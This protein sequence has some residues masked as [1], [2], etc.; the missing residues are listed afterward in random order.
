[1][2]RVLLCIVLLLAA[3]C[4]DDQGLRERVKALET[5]L[6]EA[7][8]RVDELERQTVVERDRYVD[9]WRGGPTASGPLLAL[10]RLGALRWTCDDDYGVR[11]VFTAA[12]ATVRVSYDAPDLSRSGLIHPGQRVGATVAAGESVAWT[13]AHRH[14]PGFIRAH[15]EVATARSRRGNCLVPKIRVEETGRRYD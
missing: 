15:V 5:D 13:I 12:A 8:D 2:A 1:M 6:R 9:V 7:R 10:P 11:I 4:N 3:A 14:E